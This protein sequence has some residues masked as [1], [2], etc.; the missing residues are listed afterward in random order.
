MTN[1]AHY[2][3]FDVDEVYLLQRKCTV[4]L[5][6]LI[7]TYKEPPYLATRTRGTSIFKTRSSFYLHYRYLP[8]RQGASLVE[9]LRDGAPFSCND[10]I[11][12]QDLTMSD[13]RSLDRR[14]MDGCAAA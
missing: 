12:D 7:T 2:F 6:G 4:Q 1:F 3:G 8:Y 13:H 11:P 9:L 14:W 10:V 5:A